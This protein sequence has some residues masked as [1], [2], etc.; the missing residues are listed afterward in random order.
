MK[1]TA[2]LVK[3]IASGGNGYKRLRLFEKAERSMK[4][5]FNDML[6]S[7]SY[8]KPRWNIIAVLNRKTFIQYKTDY[9]FSSEG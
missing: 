1:W 5:K 2:G 6:Y 7:D 4:A 3:K 8:P 9:R